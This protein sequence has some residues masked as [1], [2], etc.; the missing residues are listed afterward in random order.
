MATPGLIDGAFREYLTWPADFLFKL[1]DELSLDDGAMIEPLAVGVHACRRGGVAPGRSVAVLGAGPIGLLAAQA[2]AAYGAY[3]VVITDVIQPRLE[4]AGEL[5]ISAVNA[6]EED[7]VEAIREATDGGADVIIETAGTAA[8]VR[9]AMSAVR[10]GGVVVL[11]GMVAEDEVALPVIDMITR[12][13][14]VRT[15]FR[16]ANCYRPAL[17]LAAAGRIQLGPLRTHEFALDETEAALL[18]SIEKKSE[19]CKVMVKVSG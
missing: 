13:Y 5:G 14:D 11:V 18:T 4:L 19:A 6:A 9:Q 3:P 17:A 15:V 7:A 1:P 2:S 8:T 16:Y 12:E 10:T